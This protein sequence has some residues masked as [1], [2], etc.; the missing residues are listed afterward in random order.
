MT[1]YFCGRAWECGNSH[2]LNA[3]QVAKKH[4]EEEYSVVG[5]VEDLANTLLLLEHYIPGYFK[6]TSDIH[7]KFEFRA[8]VNPHPEQSD[9]VIQKLR[10]ELKI[11]LELYNFILQRFYIQLQHVRSL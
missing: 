9:R 10:E 6:G 3:L 7:S 2:S 8:N 1:T 11:D 5:I 4:I